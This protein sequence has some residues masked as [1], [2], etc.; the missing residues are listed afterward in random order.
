MN[1]KTGKISVNPDKCP[2][3][4]FCQ[5]V[6]CP[7]FNKTLCEMNCTENGRI[8]DKEYVHIVS[9]C[10]SCKCTCPEIDCDA[11]CGGEGLGIVINDTTGC[12]KCVG[13]KKIEQQGTS[14]WF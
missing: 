9:L 13:C 1:L 12:I 3:A 4:Y 2:F 7:Q 6:P 8:M 5:C 10:K 11:I 14:F